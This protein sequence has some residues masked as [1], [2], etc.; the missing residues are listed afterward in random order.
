MLAQN[1]IISWLVPCWSTFGVRT[2]HGQ[3]RTHK[4]HHDLDLGEVNTFPLT[5]YYVPLHEAHIQMAFVPGFPNGSLEI[6]KVGTLATLGS[7]NFVCRPLIEMR[8]KAKL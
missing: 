8:S 7:H 2:S 1:Q 4:T 6:A 3:S 5:V